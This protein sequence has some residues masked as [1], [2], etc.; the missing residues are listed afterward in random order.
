MTA[1]CQC[2]RCKYEWVATSKY[3]PCPSCGALGN[4]NNPKLTMKYHA[5]VVTEGVHTAWIINGKRMPMVNAMT[6]RPGA[7]TYHRT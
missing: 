2:A 7:R 6:V 3:Q 5:R 4:R 1:T